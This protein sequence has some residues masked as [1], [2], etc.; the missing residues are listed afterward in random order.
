M[1]T[2]RLILLPNWM[3]DAV[4]AE[5]A[6]RALAQ[7]QPEHPLIGAGRAVATSAL[8]GH[9]AFKELITI[10]DRGLFGPIRT[11]R[12]L[13]AT[14]AQ[15][16][17]LL[18]NSARSALVAR[19]TR[20]KRRIGY[21]RDGRGALLTTA[22]TPPP[23][24]T[25]VPAV[26]YYATLFQEAYGIS[27]SDKTPHLEISQE[28]LSR[29]QELLQGLPRPVIAMVP[30]GSKAA[31]RWSPAHYAE[32]ARVLSQ[33]HGGSS[34]L[35]GSPEEQEILDDITNQASSEVRNLTKHGLTLNTLRGVVA[36]A[37][38]LITN[39]TG[40]RHL[41]AAC[42]TPTV[43]LFGPTDHRW[44]SLPGVEESILLAEPFLDESHFADQHPEACR[45]DRISVGDVVFHASRQLAKSSSS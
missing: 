20:A 41:A 4:M 29:A 3:G 8:A 33:T 39:D 7:A 21:R 45:I 10:N 15:E 36:A 28:E 31:K 38:L 26:E 2:C 25:P 34:V 30:G 43:A 17:I 14:G 11:G 16:V 27:V 37:D 40:P 35:L 19:W 24:N 13:R 32:V 44:T 42:G 9:P 22:I 6:I 18:R 1:S 23:R 5:P 12:Q